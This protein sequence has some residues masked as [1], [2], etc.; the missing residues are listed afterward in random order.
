MEWRI[1]K[2]F[3]KYRVSDH[4]DIENITTGKR[5]KPALKR[6][7]YHSITLFKEG[8]RHYLRVHRVVAEAFLDNDNSLPVVNHRN[9]I[10]TDNRL[11]NLEWCTVSY[12]TKHAYDELGVINPNRRKVKKINPITGD[13]IREFTSLTEASRELG[14]S[15]SGISNCL[16]GDSLTSGGFIWK[17]ADEGVS[18]IEKAD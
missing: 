1:I 6:D 3:P 12:N 5:L 17:Y 10:K 11:E 15:R 8:K 13:K 2:D 7:G 14:V 4:G 18:T 9:G 16:R